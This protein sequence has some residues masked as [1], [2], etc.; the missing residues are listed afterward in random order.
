[1]DINVSIERYADICEDGG[2][3]ITN[4]VEIEVNGIVTR[5]H[6]DYA[7]DDYLRL[8]VLEKV[9]EVLDVKVHINEINRIKS[10][11]YGN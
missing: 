10:I 3:I 9:L 6:L 4:D 7:K 8:K 11:T 5:F 1:M 2:R